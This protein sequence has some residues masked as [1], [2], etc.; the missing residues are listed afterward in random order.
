MRD[1]T[2]C[3]NTWHAASGENGTHTIPVFFQ[4]LK[5]WKK[6][7]L[8]ESLVRDHVVD[9]TTRRNHRKDVFV[10]RNQHIQ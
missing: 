2:I 5:S 4:E 8:V 7:D 10:V 1:R 6:T 9:G 3:L